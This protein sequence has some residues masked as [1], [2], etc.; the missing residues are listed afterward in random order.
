MYWHSQLP[1]S[2]GAVSPRAVGGLV[3]RQGT[4]RNHATEGTGWPAGASPETPAGAP[5]A[6]ATKAPTIHT[7]KPPHST[8]PSSMLAGTAGRTLLA[9]CPSAL[10][11]FFNTR[12]ACA[13]RLVRR[14]FQAAVAAQPWEDMVTV[15]TGRIDQWR[16]CFPRARRAEIRFHPEHYGWRHTSL[17]DADF[18][19]FVGLWELNFSWNTAVTDAAFVH[20]QGIRVLHMAGCTAVT[21]AALAHLHGI[22]TLDIGGCGAIT[23]AGLAHLVGIHSLSIWDCPQITDAGFVHLGGITALNISGCNQLTDAAFA[24]LG[25]IHTLFMHLCDQLTITDAA[26]VH[27]RGIHTLV[28]EGC[29]QDTITESAFEGLG[30]RRLQMYACSDEAIAAA[31][32]Y[33]PTL[34][35]IQTDASFEVGLADGSV[36]K[37][38]P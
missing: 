30:V 25:G 34:S 27:L 36:W 14:E 10:L 23:D 19:H 37:S 20:L 11:D 8:R 21:D 12:E 24:H 28:M 6:R 35:M 16:A 7:Q 26:F 2:Q 17:E 31:A 1:A 4:Q 15:I 9:E 13:L 3:A 22:R 29:N 5:A 32:D 38:P 33:A 18:V